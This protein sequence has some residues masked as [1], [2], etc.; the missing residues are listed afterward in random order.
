[1]R[2]GLLRVDEDVAEHLD[3]LS[4][5]RVDRPEVGRRI[6]FAAYSGAAQDQAGGLLQ[7]APDRDGLLRRHAAFRERQQLP[8]QLT[9]AHARLFGL[10][11]RVRRRVRHRRPRHRHVAHDRQQ[12]VIEIV[13][14]AA[15]KK[16]ERGELAG[17]RALLLNPD[18][19]GNVSKRQHEADYTTVTVTQKRGTV[20]DRMLAEVARHQDG[21]PAGAQLVAAKRQ[22]RDGVVGRL[23]CLRITGVKHFTK[24]LT[25][26]LVGR[27]PSQHFRDAVNRKNG[28][29]EVSGDDTVGDASQ[30]HRQALFFLGERLLSVS[31]L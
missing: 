26:G 13:G 7:D 15:R 23:A 2:H 8:R 5:I 10:G 20:L 9:R 19:V 29:V 24:G 16:P 25:D 3:Q 12:N 31:R 27:P 6:D 28:A 4:F 11:Q 22:R 21:A 17:L 30:R 18:G 1:M 14:D